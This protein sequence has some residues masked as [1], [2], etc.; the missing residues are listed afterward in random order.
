MEAKIL[1]ERIKSDVEIKDLLAWPFEF[2]LIEL[3]FDKVK[4]TT[5][6]VF[7]EDD[8]GGEFCLISKSNNVYYLSSEGKVGKIASSFTEAIEI[9]VNCPYWMDLL[10]FSN[11]GRIEEMQKAKPFLIKEIKEDLPELDERIDHIIGELG[12]KKIK[13]PIAQLFQAVLSGDINELDGIEAD[14]KGLFGSFSVKDNSLW[15]KQ[16]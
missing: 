13:D 4:S 3:N 12:I 8:S 7:G 6:T 10:K 15:Y 11:N 5:Q 14:T 16:K 9:I 2:N 1:Y